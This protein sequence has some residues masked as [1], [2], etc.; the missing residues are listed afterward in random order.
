MLYMNLHLLSF[1]SACEASQV[2]GI[3]TGED[4]IGCH[5]QS[6]TNKTLRRRLTTEDSGIPPED[7]R[8]SLVR[9]NSVVRR[10]S[11]IDDSEEISQD[12]LIRNSLL[13]KGSRGSSTT[14]DN[15]VGV[16][17]RS[18]VPSRRL[19]SAQPSSLNIPQHRRAPA[20]R[21]TI[22]L[23]R[24]SSKLSLTASDLEDGMGLVNEDDKETNLEGVQTILKQILGGDFKYVEVSV[25][26]NWNVFALG[27]RIDRHGFVKLVDSL[28]DDD[29]SDDEKGTMMKSTKA[30][31]KRSLE[32]RSSTMN[33]FDETRRHLS[34]DSMED[35]DEFHIKEALGGDSQFSAKHWSLLY[36]GGSQPVVDQLKD[37]K[38]KF[39]IGLS[40]EKFDW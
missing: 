34:L 21:S 2:H 18:S 27:G 4:E 10:R 40:V 22:S 5:V 16:T 7:L 17:R 31:V 39:G 36:C 32:K 23:L 26:E 3:V 20:R 33:L 35:E 8:R 37:F 13:R 19:T 9:K 24:L 11:S 6:I 25:E 29:N 15:G 38:H 12:D 30:V 1:D 14:G 28:L